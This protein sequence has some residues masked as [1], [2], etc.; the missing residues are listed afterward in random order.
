VPGI[1]QRPCAENG[2]VAIIGGDLVDEPELQRLV[3]RDV[4]A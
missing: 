1:R 3:S 4:P 2:G